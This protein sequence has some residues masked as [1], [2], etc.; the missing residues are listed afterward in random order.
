VGDAL[1][2]TRSDLVVRLY[3]QDS[4][5]LRRK[6]EEVRRLVAGVDGVVDP[7]VEVQRQEPTLEVETD[8]G[9]ARRHGIKPGD[10]RRAATALLSGIVV[11]SLFENQKVFEV[12]VRG[13]PSMQATPASIEALLIDTPTGDQVRLDEIASVRVVPY[14]TVIRHDATLRSLDVTAGVSGRDLG[15]VLSDVN[16]RVRAVPMPLEYHAEVISDL[17]LQ[18]G[19]DLQTTA[20][21]VGV[22]IAIYL[23]LQAALGSWR[24][25]AAVLLTLPLAAAG[26]VLAAFL[27][28]GVTTLGA[29]IGLFTVLAIAARNSV[30]LVSSYQRLAPSGTTPPTFESVMAVTRERVGAIL[31]TAGATAAVFLPLVLLGTMA[32]AQILHPL[33]V[34]VLGGLVTSTVLTVFVLPSLY[35]RLGFAAYPEGPLETESSSGIAG[36]LDR[37]VAWPRRNR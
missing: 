10:V 7:R 21:A 23:L 4:A 28:G 34:V 24:L 33:A 32:G 5:V 25:A 14:P 19:K 6:A 29:L 31:L 9:A 20:L 17:A 15:A 22:V 11:G 18:Q 36:R 12:V 2:G 26:G 1:T 3:G 27:V 35:V 30:V 16:D 37:L 8:L 13:T